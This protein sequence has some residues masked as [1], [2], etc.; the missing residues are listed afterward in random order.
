MKTILLVSPYWKEEHRWM[1][2]SFKLAAL[3]QK[4]GYKVIAVCMGKE[5]RTEK[6]SDTLEVHYRKDLFLKD[7]WNYGIC[8]GFSRY[9]LRLAKE[10]NPDYIIVNKLLFWSS[11]S[12]IPLRLTGRKVLLLTDAFVGMTWWP[13]GKVPQVCAAVYAWTLGWLILLCAS[14][15]VT[16][17]PQPPRLL[18]LLGIAKKTSVI[19]TGIDSGIRRK[20]TIDTDAITISYVGRLESVK[21]VDDFLAALVPLKKEFS[22][23]KIQVV[24]WYAEG[25]PLV[26]QYQRDVVFMGLRDDVDEILH[27]TN[28]FVMP[29]YSEGLSNAIMEAMSADCACVVSEVGGNTFLVQ[30]GVSGFHF[31]A[32]DRQALASHVRRLLADPMKM[33]SLGENARKRIETEFDWKVVSKKYQSLFNSV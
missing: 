26:E 7:P 16:F 12:L 33:K 5:T 28:I 23:L 31:P 2:S 27:K 6:V 11:I 19:P 24:G 15:I 1:V 22:G 29:S 13:R 14:R 17:H 21:G 18:K 20:K 32:G 9:V 25:H 4:L 3:W 8:F 10:G 30:N